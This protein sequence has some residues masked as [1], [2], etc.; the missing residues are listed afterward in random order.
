M[1]LDSGLSSRIKMQVLFWILSGVTL[2][3]HPRSLEWLFLLQVSGYSCFTHLPHFCF[4]ILR[5]DA[6]HA[7]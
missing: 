7:L 1:K 2:P 4:P 3:P 5:R 6:I